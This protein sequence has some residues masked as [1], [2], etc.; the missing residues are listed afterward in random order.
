MVLLEVDRDADVTMM[1][2]TTDS[3]NPH[4]LVMGTCSRR[5]QRGLPRLFRFTG[6]VPGHVYH[7]C[8]SGVN[9]RDALLRI[10]RFR[11]IHKND[12]DTRIVAVAH[13]VPSD[14]A[15]EDGGWSMWEQVHQRIKDGELDLVVHCGAQVSTAQ[16]AHWHEMMGPSDDSRLVV[17]LFSFPS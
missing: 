1:V 13:S 6:L 2:S 11:T 15:P 14:V 10:G 9:R 12:I 3:M 5:M 16:H 17:F 8:T 7:V 4:G